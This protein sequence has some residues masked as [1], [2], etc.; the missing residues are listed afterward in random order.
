M[1]RFLWPSS[2]AGHGLLEFWGLGGDL[3][4][5]VRTLLQWDQRG[6][7]VHNPDPLRAQVCQAAIA[8][9][10]PN[11]HLPVNRD[12]LDECGGKLI[13][14]PK[15]LRSTIQNVFPVKKTIKST[16]EFV[17]MFPSPVE[18]SNFLGGL[19]FCDLL[20]IVIC[21]TFFSWYVFDKN[22]YL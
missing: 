9:I 1:W 4:H 14:L 8:W 7:G 2:I 5:K 17:A 13:V 21:F 18:L 20:C 15:W 19:P 3:L 22:V 16:I 6:G 10:R 12:S 11:V